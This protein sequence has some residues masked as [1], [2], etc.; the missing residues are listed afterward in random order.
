MAISCAALFMVDGTA[1]D[2]RAT[3]AKNVDEA[4]KTAN[5]PSWFKA[6][7]DGILWFHKGDDA[8][9][10]Y[11]AALV[12]SAVTDG[13]VITVSA[14]EATIN[15]ALKLAIKMQTVLQRSEHTPEKI[16][17]VATRDELP[18][19]GYRFYTDGMGCSIGDKSVF[20]PSEAKTKEVLSQVVK[21]YRVLKEIAEQ[22]RWGKDDHTESVLKIVPATQ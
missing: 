14:N 11:S 20:T 13:I 2:V 19:V 5:Q 21:Q 6:D 16:A 18:G 1:S 15:D 9:T 10:K 3:D 4:E 12:L 8:Q 22:G 17:I 7:Q